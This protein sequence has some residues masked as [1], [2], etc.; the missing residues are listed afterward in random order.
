MGPRTKPMRAASPCAVDG[1]ACIIGVPDLGSL[2]RFGDKVLLSSIASSLA[3]A[4]ELGRE[5][6]LQRARGAPDGRG[7]LSQVAVY[8]GG[9]PSSMG[10]Q[11]GGLKT[12][13]KRNASW[14]LL[15]DC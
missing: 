13:C 2:H 4:S 14:I 3:T 10:T 8:G 9:R 6:S 7:W 11:R 12:V 1:A 15:Q 5:I